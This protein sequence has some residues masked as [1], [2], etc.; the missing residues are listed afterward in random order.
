[1]AV[2]RFAVT[3]EALD[4]FAAG[5]NL[6]EFD[7]VDVVGFF[8]KMATKADAFRHFALLLDLFFVT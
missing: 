3:S 5:V 2:G 7:R 4:L 1:M 8:V 6:M